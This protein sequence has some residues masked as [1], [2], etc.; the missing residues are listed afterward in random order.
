MSI[1]KKLDEIH[2][3]IK[4]LCEEI[5]VIRN[6]LNEIK[7]NIENVKTDTNKMSTHI[8]FVNGVYDSYKFSL[9]YINSGITKFLG[10]N[11]TQNNNQID[12]K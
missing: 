7:A 9:S 4:L 12:E 11:K 6:E 1:E 10:Y 8:N 3:D 5:K 2:N